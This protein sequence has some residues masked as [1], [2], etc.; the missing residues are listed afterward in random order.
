MDQRQSTDDLI[1]MDG[2][3]LK[4]ILRTKRYAAFDLRSGRGLV[5]DNLLEVMV[6]TGLRVLMESRTRPDDLIYLS[7]SD[8]MTQQ[9]GSFCTIMGVGDD[10][11]VACFGISMDEWNEHG[12]Q[13]G[14]YVPPGEVV[15]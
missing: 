4:E 2:E 5:G 3:R 7:E 1:D 13:G 14:T 10:P 15:H 12:P 6:F 11:I 9:V 8:T